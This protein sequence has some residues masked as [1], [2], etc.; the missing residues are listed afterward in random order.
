[1]KLSSKEANFLC[2]GGLIMS[3]KRS[4][5]VCL[6]RRSTSCERPGGNRH[7]CRVR[8][9][10]KLS[11]ISRSLPTSSIMETVS[12]IQSTCRSWQRKATRACPRMW[13]I[14]QLPR[15]MSNPPNISRTIRHLH[16]LRKWKKW[17]FLKL[18][19][20]RTWSIWSR[21][22]SGLQTKTPKRPTRTGK[23]ANRTSN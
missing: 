6:T 23:L 22:W 18:N 19:K 12:V 15:M 8:P 1:M 21:I 16:C 2:I 20:S 14:T 3:F 11:L 9:P 10:S 4:H 13:E 7:A 5:T 17:K